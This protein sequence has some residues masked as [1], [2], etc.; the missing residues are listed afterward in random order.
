MVV[1]VIG[2]NRLGDVD[3]L[4]AVADLREVAGPSEAVIR[5]VAVIRHMKRAWSA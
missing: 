5:N 4:S 3:C 1:A 2:R